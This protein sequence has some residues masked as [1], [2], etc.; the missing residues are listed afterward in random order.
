M[1]TLV[2]SKGFVLHD[3]W[4]STPVHILSSLWKLYSQNLCPDLLLHQHDAGHRT[5]SI[6]PSPPLPHSLA[7]IHGKR[8]KPGASYKWSKMADE[9]AASGEM[10]EDEKKADEYKLK[11]NEFFKGM[12]L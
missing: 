1:S 10:T 8:E 4:S 2:I 5:K 9:K 12:V 7:P 11:A 6:S 3:H